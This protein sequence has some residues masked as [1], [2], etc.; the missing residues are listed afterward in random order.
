V[1]ERGGWRGAGRLAG[2]GAAV[3]LATALAVALRF[4]FQPTPQAALSVGLIA[5]L[6]LLPGAAAGLAYWRVARGLPGPGAA[7]A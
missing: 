4:G 1:V 3:G 5:A 7:A 2:L 6:G